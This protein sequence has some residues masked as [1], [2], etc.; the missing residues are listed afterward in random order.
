VQDFYARNGFEKV[1]DDGTTATFRHDLADIAAP[2]EHITFT[3]D[4]RGDA[5]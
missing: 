2:P 5:P 1:R 3:D 4:L